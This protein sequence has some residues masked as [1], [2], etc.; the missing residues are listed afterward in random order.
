MYCVYVYLKINTNILN[1][2]NPDPQHK[3]QNMPP[4]LPSEVELETMID[5]ILKSVY[6]FFL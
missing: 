4:P 2:E 1:S 3:G 5:S 6:Y